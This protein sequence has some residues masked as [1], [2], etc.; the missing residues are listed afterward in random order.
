MKFNITNLLLALVLTL[1]FFSCGS[2]NKPNGEEKSKIEQQAEKS[3]KRAENAFHEADSL[4][5]L[6]A[7]TIAA[8]MESL[9][10]KLE[11]KM[12]KED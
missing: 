5:V 6:A 3:I 9:G 12:G 2:S 10:K 4:A 1:I 7:D 8:E 11:E